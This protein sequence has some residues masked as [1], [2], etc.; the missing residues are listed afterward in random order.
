MNRVCRAAPLLLAATLLANCAAPGPL[1]AWQGKLEGVRKEVREE[2]GGSR[3]VRRGGRRHRGEEDDY[4]VAGLVLRWVI[5]SPF[6]VPIEVAQDPL[7]FAGF[8]P[9]HPYQDGF[10]G[11]QYFEGDA[12]EGH[13][14]ARLSLEDGDDFQGL[15]RAGA[16]LLVSSRWRLGLEG[17]FDFLRESLP[18]RSDDELLLGDVN[19][20]FRFAQHENFQFR[21]GLGYRFLH[22]DE[23]DEGGF[24]WLYAADFY[25]HRP[26]VISGRFDAGT[27]GSADLFR[28]RLTLGAL[29]EGMELFAGYDHLQVERVEIY[30]PLVGLRAWF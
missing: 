18:D 25:P 19:L 20:V 11:Y 28:A 3:R 6:W 5:L 14:A 24:N 27:L 30:G 16:R 8:F 29:W 23:G 9:S 22:D 12:E 21:T 10:P 26:W 17:G 15:N 1:P 2:K 4:W 13:W 7:D